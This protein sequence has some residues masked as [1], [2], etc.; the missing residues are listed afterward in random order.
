MLNRIFGKKFHDYFHLFGISA[1][2][3]GLPSSKIIL[4]IATILILLNLLLEAD[5]GNYW[6]NIK[7]NRIF[8]ILTAYF[9]LHLIGL[10]WSA[11]F[12]YAFQDIR[13]KLTI[14]ILPLVIVSKP[15]E[16]E[17]QLRNI[18]LLFCAALVF[19]SLVNFASYQHW[20][21][22][23]IYGDIRALSLF[24]SHIRY[25]ILI[26]MGAAISLFY[27]WKLE[28]AKKWFLVP[29]LVWF[30]FYTY[31]SQIISGFLALVLILCTFLL[32][33]GFRKSKR[34]GYSLVVMLFLLA[35]LPSVYLFMNLKEQT[36]IDL[37]PL[38]SVSPF[39]NPYTH[40][41][42]PNTYINGKPIFTYLCEEELKKAWNDR[43]SL[44]YDSLDNRKQPLRIT[45][46]R[47]MSTKGLRKDRTDFQKLTTKDIRFIE[48]GV[49]SIQET[50]TG[51]PARFEGIKFQ[52]NNSLDPNGHS[53]LQRLEFWKTG[54]TIIKENWIFGVGT[55]DVQD[56]FDQQYAIENSALLPV[57]RLRA[58]NAYLTNWISFGILGLLLFIWMHVAFFVEN[59]KNGNILPLLFCIVAM[60]TFFIEDTLET[61]MGAAF[62]AFFY[63]LFLPKKELIK[64][65]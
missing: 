35:L 9:S 53:L 7:T 42:N 18:L 21:G 58:H 1:F 50:K 20:F 3:I 47:Y 37:S 8:L 11:D 19:T 31:Y 44:N 57:N 6:R 62:F 5:Y 2:S 10:L 52:L 55:G 45:L 40:N 34:F 17:K 51:F 12:E 41:V 38:E 24:G 13:I 56:A 60:T 32:F 30:C 33:V 48:N 36:K 16:S 61:Q 25:G 49:A 15:L 4:S 28:S 39:G 23:K 29:V 54:W 26:A 65:D 46:I 43:S 22:T 63:A 27:I 64:A 59:Y 14:F